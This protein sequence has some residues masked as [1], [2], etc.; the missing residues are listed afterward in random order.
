MQAENSILQQYRNCALKRDQ[1]ISRLTA[2][3][4]C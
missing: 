2:L 3:I 1:K 4:S